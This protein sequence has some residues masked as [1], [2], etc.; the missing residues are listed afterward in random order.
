MKGSVARRRL[1]EAFESVPRCSADAVGKRLLDG[2]TPLD[3][4][5]RHR[6]AGPTRLSMILILVRKAVECR[7]Q[8]AAQLRRREEEERRQK[9]QVCEFLEKQRRLTRDACNQLGQNSNEC[10][11][12]RAEMDEAVEEFRRAGITCP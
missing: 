3:K 4:L 11:A 10:R 12:L 1:E 7:N 6:L 9:R 8:L 2:Q 5:F